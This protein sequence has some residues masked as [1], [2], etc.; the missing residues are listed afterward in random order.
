MCLKS[1]VSSGHAQQPVTR[2]HHVYLH[3]TLDLQ[4]NAKLDEVE[5]GVVLA[6]LG[7]C[8]MSYGRDG[9]RR[10]VI[11]AVGLTLSMGSILSC[12]GGEST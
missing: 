6:L 10:V 7:A 11:V 4:S 3:R 2:I 9:P 5:I 1:Q 8:I 12:F